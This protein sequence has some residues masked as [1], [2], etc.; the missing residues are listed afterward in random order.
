M[1]KSMVFV[2]L[3]LLTVVPDL[4]A[5]PWPLGTLTTKD[6][7]KGTCPAGSSCRVFDVTCPGV[8]AP[9]QGEIAVASA[10]GKA[11]GLVVFFTGSFGNN[12]W[13]KENPEG[14]AFLD[15]LRKLGFTIVQ[16]RWKGPW[17]ASSPG[18][19]A[20]VAHLACRPATVIRHIYD[21]IY[22]PLGGSVSH[23]GEAGFCITGNSGGASQVSFALSHYGLEN[24]LD[25]VIPTG[26][27]PHADL[28]KACLD[29]EE[30]S[31]SM[32]HLIDRSFGYVKNDGPCL[33]RDPSVA[34][35]WLQESVATGGNDYNHPKTRINFLIGQKDGLM[36]R[37]GRIYYDRLRKEGSPMVTWETIPATQHR[38]SK[39]ANGL[40]SL[41][42]AILESIQ[43][44]PQSASQMR[45]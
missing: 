45:D 2:F 36:Q 37:F 18:Y 20:G 19:D 15:E 44:R 27:P 1:K 21:N 38:I 31:A 12:W 23:S 25:V 14:G 29:K 5:K 43:E 32:R 28:H 39:T 22:L 16:V 8:D 40:R 35:R 17:L 34:S 6:N 26:G 11:R 13:I 7:V 9:G 41:K 33:Q 10:I 24:I 3:Y 4:F 42:I 30:L